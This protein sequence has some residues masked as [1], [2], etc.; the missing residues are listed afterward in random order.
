[1][2][3]ILL[4]LWL[5]A[6]TVK[7]QRT[8]CWDFLLNCWKLCE[9][10][11]LYSFR[12]NDQLLHILYHITELHFYF[13][14]EQHTPSASDSQK[15]SNDHIFMLCIYFVYNSNDVCVCHVL[16]DM[17]CI[18]FYQQSPLHIQACN[19]LLKQPPFHMRPHNQPLELSQ[20]AAAHVNPPILSQVMNQLVCCS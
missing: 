8:V 17:L 6:S 4:S 5:L 11:N 2:S 3:C 7:K 10:H 19:Q 14:T 16:C 15:W 9:Q 1:M 18:N 13:D 20:S 12:A